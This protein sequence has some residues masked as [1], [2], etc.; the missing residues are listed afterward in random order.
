LDQALHSLPTPVPALAEGIEDILRTVDKGDPD[1]AINDIVREMLN[2]YREEGKRGNQGKDMDKVGTALQKLADAASGYK[3]LKEQIK[4]GVDPVI[5]NAEVYLGLHPPERLQYLGPEDQLSVDSEK[6]EHALVEKTKTFYVEAKKNVMGKELPYLKPLEHKFVAEDGVKTPSSQRSMSTGED[7]VSFY[8]EVDQKR[9][10]VPK[11]PDSKVYR[12]RGRKFRPGE[13]EALSK[14]REGKLTRPK[15]GFEIKEW[16]EPSGDWLKGKPTLKRRYSYEDVRPK[17]GPSTEESHEDF[18]RVYE[19][20]P[21]TATPKI[22]QDEGK[23]KKLIPNEELIKSNPP[24]NSKFVVLKGPN[25]DYHL[26]KLNPYLDPNPLAPPALLEHSIR[27]GSTSTRSKKKSQSSSQLPPLPPINFYTR[28]PYTFHDL[29]IYCSHS[30]PP[31]PMS[32]P[33]MTKEELQ[34]L[35]KPIRHSGGAV[36]TQYV[37]TPETMDGRAIVEAVLRIKEAGR[38]IE[39]MDREGR[40]SEGPLEG[41]KT[42]EDDLLAS[43]PQHAKS[44]NKLGTDRSSYGGSKKRGGESGVGDGEVRKGEVKAKEGGNVNGKPFYVVERAAPPEIPE[45]S[46]VEE[47]EKVDG[48]GPL[49]ELRKA[50]ELSPKLSDAQGIYNNLSRGYVDGR[51]NRTDQNRMIDRLFQEMDQEARKRGYLF[52]DHFFIPGPSSLVNNS[53]KSSLPYK[54]H[55][56]ERIP[57]IFENP[58]FLN[59]FNS[60]ELFSKAKPGN[61]AFCIILA[62]LSETPS[63][64]KQ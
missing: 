48:D 15:L 32:I 14:E 20:D 49:I 8:E 1:G 44:P 18:F 43:V 13:K 63:R 38:D 2:A 12:R 5:R 59:N 27:P 50:M 51:D 47:K 3:G 39:A 6:K 22:Q 42:V 11:V 7:L 37:Q 4:N 10:E 17:V 55:P 61:E 40:I 19:V 30:I 35:L 62:S 60:N 58:V 33:A 24:E 64:V 16:L 41:V 45:E 26:I 25:N 52:D 36:L 9:P 53:L 56:W 54:D 31:H 23:I 46:D 28:T 57:D 29:P 21:T 34:Q